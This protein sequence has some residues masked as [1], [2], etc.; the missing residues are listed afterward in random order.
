MTGVAGR[1]FSFWEHSF[2]RPDQGRVGDQTQDEDTEHG[3][4]DSF[5]H[6]VFPFSGHGS[7]NECPWLLLRYEQDDKGPAKEDEH[8]EYELFHQSGLHNLNL[9]YFSP[10]EKGRVTASAA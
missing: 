2:L 3:H 8:K 5:R 4:K 10:S 1:I 6:R 7:E 9:L